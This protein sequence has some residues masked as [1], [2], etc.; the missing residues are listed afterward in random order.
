MPNISKRHL[1]PCATL[2][3]LTSATQRLGTGVVEDPWNSSTATHVQIGPRPRPA[4]SWSAGRASLCELQY[5]VRNLDA[6]RKACILQALHCLCAAL[7]TGVAKSCFLLRFHARGS[8]LASTL[9]RNRSRELGTS[10][11]FAVSDS[12]FSPGPVCASSRS[13][14]TLTDRA[15]AQE[16]PGLV[17]GTEHESPD[18]SVMSSEWL[19]AAVIDGEQWLTR[20]GGDPEEPC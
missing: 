20:G 19:L 16:L 18:C 6:E 13:R 15:R 1:C 2:G 11:H 8:A 7:G 12:R 4:E 10:F 17:R 3:A 5:K 9:W 14:V